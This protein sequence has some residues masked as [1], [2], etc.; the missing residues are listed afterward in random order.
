MTITKFGFAAVLVAC[1]AIAQGQGNGNGRPPIDT[2]VINTPSVTVANTPNVVIANDVADPV[3]VSVIATPES[4]VMCYQSLG[5]SGGGG[6]FGGGSSAFAQSLVN[7]PDGVN[8]VD[9]QRVVFSPDIGGA[10]STSHIAKYRVTVSFSTGLGQENIAG[11]LAILTDGAPQSTI[12]Q[13]FR[14]DTTD[15][16]MFINATRDF[17][18]GIDGVDVFLTGTLYFIGTPVP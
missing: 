17:T 18:S 10:G 12:A 3:L 9:V 11:F 13:N 2:V 14:L 1:S 8:R 16:N 6:P 15:E 4:S 5:G 7:C